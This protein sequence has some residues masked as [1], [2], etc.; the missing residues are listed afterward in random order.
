MSTEPRFR[1]GIG[2]MMLI[3]LIVAVTSSGGYYAV[4]ALISGDPRQQ[5]NAVIF[6][7][8]T[9]M[10][11]VICAN[12]IRGLWRY[13][14]QAQAQRKAQRRSLAELDEEGNWK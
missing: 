5:F 12:F 13:V 8:V 10:A 6:T 14:E 3:T 11:V 1:F 7:L 9:P 4:K 2:T